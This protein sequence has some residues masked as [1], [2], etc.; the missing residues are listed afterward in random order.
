LNEKELSVHPTFAA[1]PFWFGLLA[2]ISHQVAAL[3]AEF[4]A[5]EA[6]IARLVSEDEQR[7]TLLA[8][9]KVEMRRSRQHDIGQANGSRALQNIKGAKHVR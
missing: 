2:C 6:T 9:D 3:R 5:G 4:S 7:E 8:S 1:V